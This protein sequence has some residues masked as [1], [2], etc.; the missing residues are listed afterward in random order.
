MKFI[1][2]PIYWG[3]RSSS[4]LWYWAVRRLTPAGLCVVL[5]LMLTGTMGVD[6]EN[7]V[8]YQS[9]ALLLALLIFSFKCSFF[10]RGSFFAKRLLPRFGTVGQPLHYQV[11]V[12][13]LTAKNQI[14]LTLLDDLADPRPPFDDWLAHELAKSRRIRPFR[15]SKRG[16]KT[17]YRR[18][19]AKAAAMAPIPVNGEVSVPMQL[20]PLRRGILHFDGLT[21]ACPDPLG[22]FRSFSRVNAPQTVLVLPKRYPLP[23]IALPGRVKYQEGGV[24]LATNVGSS[25][26]F[27]S[28]RDY[29]HGDPIRH[30]HWRS[31]AKI[32]K[33]IVKEFE[34]EFFVRH[35]LVLDTFTDEPQ[36]EVLEEAVSVA[37]SFA[38]TVL[39][40]ESLLD[41]LF[42]GIKSYCFTAGRGLGTSDQILEILA[43]ARNCPDKPFSALEHLVFGHISMVSGCICIFQ[44]WDDMRRKFI[45]KLKAVNVPVMVLIVVPPGGGIS[46]AGGTLVDAEGTLHVLEVGKIEEGLS[47]LK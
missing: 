44:K 30:I 16:E 10:F 5:G 7:T 37:A 34:D 36:S 9:F 4:G 8:L 19:T 11:L 29:R 32:G 13:N 17:P 3:Y 26:E 15:V 45:E 24:A 47:K 28:L 1:Y 6:I 41:L 22:L 23:S 2:K 27:V 33:P 12:Q 40:Q 35:A 38:C 20:V 43:S 18:S 42:V 31:W 25:E 14:G 21:V 39:T 46:G